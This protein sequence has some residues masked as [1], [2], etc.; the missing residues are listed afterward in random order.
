MALM[1]PPGRTAARLK[2]RPPVKSRRVPSDKRDTVK[3]ATIHIGKRHRQHLGDVR[4]LA[5][6]IRNLGLLHPVVIDGKGRLVAGARRLAAVRLLGWKDV[7]VRVVH[8]LSDAANALR[9]ER[10]ENV[11]RKAFVPSELVSIT[12]QLEPLERAEARLRLKHGGRPKQGQKKSSGKLPDHFTGNTRDKLAAV[13]GV[14][15]RT[16]E[17]ARAVVEAAEDDPHRYGALVVEMDKTGNISGAF[18]GLQRLQWQAQAAKARL[19][20]LPKHIDVRRCSM[21]T[22]LSDLH[23]VDAIVTDPMYDRASIPV[24]GELARLSARA[25]RPGGTLAVMCGKFCLPEILGLMTPHL[26]F[27]TVV[28]LLLGSGTG[29][30]R[31]HARKVYSR[32]KALAIFTNGT[33]SGWIYDVI[34]SPEDS[35][36][37]RHRYEQSEH[38]FVEL[39]EMLTEPGDLVCD[40]LL[41]SGTTAV[42]CLKTGRHFVGGDIDA[43]AVRI[44]RARLSVLL[45][46]PGQSH[47]PRHDTTAEGSAARGNLSLAR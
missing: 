25:L 32:W 15:G 18:A 34:S 42:A 4:S 31:L 10:D 14:S 21:D 45:R 33:P 35:G 20:S 13:V 5:A 39:V 36:R 26:T 40:P 38:G 44:T 19:I 11:E 2:L 29:H 30:S 7:P 17:K 23:D 46:E 37:V 3:L 12:R 41:G 9:A 8:N 6:S 22:L 24:Y 43:A 28:A 1:R 47:G 27:R 16:L